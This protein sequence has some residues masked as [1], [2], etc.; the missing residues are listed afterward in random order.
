MTCEPVR[1]DGRVTTVRSL[2][3]NTSLKAVQGYDDV[4]GVGTPANGYV[5]SYRRH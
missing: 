2:G 1:C 5:E 4:T 3:E